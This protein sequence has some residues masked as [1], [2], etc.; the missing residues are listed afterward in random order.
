MI[1]VVC[2]GVVTGGVWV[3]GEWAVEG[4]VGEV[5]EEGGGVIDGAF[6]G[7]ICLSG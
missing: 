6:H 7:G 3:G 4:V 1:V 2:G 5:E